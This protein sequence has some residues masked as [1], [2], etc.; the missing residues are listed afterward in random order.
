MLAD[1]L[2][3]KKA[4]LKVKTEEL[5]TNSKIKNIRDVYRDI[6]DLKRKVIWLQTSTVFWLGGGTIS[7]SC[8][9]YMGLMMLGREKYPQ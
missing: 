4:Y 3:K 5:E 2:G 8:G 9:I 6:N 7:L 1:I